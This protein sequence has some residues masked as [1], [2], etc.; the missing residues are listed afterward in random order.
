MMRHSA[1]APVCGLKDLALSARTSGSILFHMKQMLNRLVR[2]RAVVTWCCLATGSG[3][4]LAQDLP[5]TLWLHAG[6]VQLAGDS[7]PALR[8]TTTAVWDSL[9]VSF[10]TAEDTPHEIVL[11]NQ[12]SVDHQFVLAAPGFEPVAM[13]AGG[14]A[15]V[16]LPGLPAGSY[17][18]HLGSERGHVLGASGVMVVGFDDLPHYHWNLGDWEPAR[19]AAVA[20]GGTVDPDA[21]YVPRQFTI[22]DRVHPTTMG[23][24]AGHVQIGVGE[25]CY[26]TIV[27]QGSMDHVL[28]FHGFHFEILQSTH[29]SERIG[30]TKDTMPFLQGEV[31]LVRLDAFQAGTYPVHN[32][33]LI[34]VT[35]AGLYPG[36]MITHLDIAP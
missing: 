4:V 22:N 1:R 28:H 11:V 21:P 12:D 32:H 3:V 14:A 26:I 25:S 19:M 31:T 27:N 29:H 6:E 24:P 13:P 10:G 18:Y 17:R 35:N 36:G 23:D 16:S 8:W 5:D 34:A 30:W 7:M 20:A 2:Q 33:N 15:S 9:N